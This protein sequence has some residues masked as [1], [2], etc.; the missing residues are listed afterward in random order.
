[1]PAFSTGVERHAINRVVP[2]FTHTVRKMLKPKPR[3]CDW[4]RRHPA[5]SPTNLH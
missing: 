5:P 2:L 1:M 3:H 4:S